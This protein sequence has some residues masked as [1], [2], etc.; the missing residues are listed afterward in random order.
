[1]PAASFLRIYALLKRDMLL[2]VAGSSRFGLCGAC[3]KYGRSRR[4]KDQVMPGLVE[5]KEETDEYDY[6]KAKTALMARYTRPLRER[7]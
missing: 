2:I 3:G 4:G 1:M 7:E 5:K 6:G